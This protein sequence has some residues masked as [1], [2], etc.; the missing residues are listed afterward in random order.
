MPVEASH[1]W[2]RSVLRQFSGLESE[3]TV[4]KVE[5]SLILDSLSV[6]SER[7]RLIFTILQQVGSR[8]C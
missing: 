7:L 1:H 6:S 3:G 5:E 4:R 2:R 8:Q